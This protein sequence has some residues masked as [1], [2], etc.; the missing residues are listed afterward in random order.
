[1]PSFPCSFYLLLFFFFFPLFHTSS[2]SPL[3]LLSNPH[4]CPA[5][6]NGFPVD[7]A[8]DMASASALASRSSVTAELLAAAYEEGTVDWLKSVRRKIHENPELQFEEFDTSQLIRDELE[9]MGIPYEW[10]LATT[11]V[12]GTLGS[13][14]PPIVALRADMDAL[15]IQV[16]KTISLNLV[17]LMYSM[18][19]YACTRDMTT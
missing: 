14:K 12:V 8:S 3:P 1:M 11:G 10:P 17:L 16:N 18:Y 9:K 4:S 13:G 2:I 6:S 7:S 19:Q 5:P 15:P